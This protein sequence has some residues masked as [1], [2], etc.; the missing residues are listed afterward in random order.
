MV[1]HDGSDANSPLSSSKMRLSKWLPSNGKHQ[2]GC[3]SFPTLWKTVY[4][5]LFMQSTY[6]HFHLKHT[7]VMPM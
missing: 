7:V 3:Y 5:T 2:P 4:K 6:L 1:E